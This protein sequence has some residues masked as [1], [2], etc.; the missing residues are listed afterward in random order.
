MTNTEKLQTLRDH[1]AWRMGGDGA[2]PLVADIT[3]AID[4][5]IQCC[6]SVQSSANTPRHDEITEPGIYL[7]KTPDGGIELI[8]LFQCQIDA[9]EVYK[10]LAYQGPLLWVE[11]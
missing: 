10:G 8:A 1:Q 2:P 4:Y 3:A 5:A 7:A 6:E 9:G 11:E